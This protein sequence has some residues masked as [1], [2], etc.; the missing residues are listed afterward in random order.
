VRRRITPA[1]RRLAEE[2]A[3]ALTAQGLTLW[4]DPMRKLS[5]RSSKIRAAVELVAAGYTPTQAAAEVGSPPHSVRSACRAQ[6]LPFG[7]QQAR[8]RIRQGLLRKN[9]EPEPDG[10]LSVAACPPLS[11]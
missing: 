4:M 8:E 9:A 2:R 3:D 11:E 5:R 10:T 6:G 7:D 1:G